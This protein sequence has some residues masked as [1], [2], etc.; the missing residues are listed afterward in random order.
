MSQVKAT[1]HADDLFDAI[2]IFLKELPDPKSTRKKSIS[3]SFVTEKGQVVLEAKKTK[4]LEGT[5]WNVGVEADQHTT[6]A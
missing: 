4:G 6:P 2:R 1:S 5:I 3:A